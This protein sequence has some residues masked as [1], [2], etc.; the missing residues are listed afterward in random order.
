M[1]EMWEYLN[2]QKF[3]KGGKLMR[4]VKVVAILSLLVFGIGS[5]LYACSSDTSTSED[6][7]GSAESADNEANKEIDFYLLGG[8][9]PTQDMYIEE[10]S[11]LS[12]YDLNFEFTPGED[13]Y[14]KLPVLFASGDLPD[15]IQTDGIRTSQHKGALESDVFLELGPL[16]EE[17]GQNILENVPEGM[18]DSPRISEDGKIYALPD[19]ASSPNSLVTFI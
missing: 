3:I 18:W 1:I 12:G 6:K 2:I 7:E 14:E 10:L 11:E 15:V 16:L 9:K 13:Y 17:H 5:I 4:K 8:D 19:P